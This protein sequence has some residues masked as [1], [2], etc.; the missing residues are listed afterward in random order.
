MK[1]KNLTP[2]QTPED[3]DAPIFLDDPSFRLSRE[4]MR[5]MQLSG[6]ITMRVRSLADSLSTRSLD[7]NEIN[8]QRV[9]GLQGNETA[10]GKSGTASKT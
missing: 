3:P 9:S 5:R 10:S 1:S 4:E 2:S 8:S 6:E 7:Q